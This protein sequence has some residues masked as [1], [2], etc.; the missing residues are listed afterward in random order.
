[1][2]DLA[3]SVA[4]YPVAT[5][6]PKLLADIRVRFPRVKVRVKVN[7]AQYLVAHLR[8]EEL[9]FCLADMRNV[10][11]AADLQFTRIGLLEAGFFVRNGHPLLSQSLMT[12]AD[13]VQ[14]GLASVQVHDSILLMLGPLMGLAAGT[15]MP[16]ALECDDLSLLTTVTMETDTVLAWPL[17]FA[18]HTIEDHHLVRIDVA[19]LPTL[20]S[21]LGV[22]ALKRRSFSPLAGH[23][24]DW[25][26]SAMGYQ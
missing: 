14:H 13:I 17:E 6:V 25:L 20:G 12:G 22:L 2:G 5:I 16:L 9:D 7:N 1:M 19:G 21:D 15:R 3:I 4:P 24:I 26:M 8:A 23:A 18:V 10:P 11:Q